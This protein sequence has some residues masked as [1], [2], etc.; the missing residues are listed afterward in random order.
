MVFFMTYVSSASEKFSDLELNELLEKSRSNNLLKGLTGMLLY[1]DGDFV[2]TLEGDKE[3]V[4]ELYKIIEKDPRHRYIIK[5]AQGFQPERKFS[6]WSMGF[7]ALK[8]EELAPILGFKTFD[9]QQ[10][11]QE[12]DWEDNH[13]AVV[14]M[15]SFYE[16]QPVHRKS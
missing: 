3:T 12:L 11:F 6:N 5:V 9:R 1:C 15:R 8:P 13:P 4:E 16:N 7:Q 14:V 2:Q 10:L